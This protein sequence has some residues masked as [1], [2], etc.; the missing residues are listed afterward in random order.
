VI[1]SPDDTRQTARRGE[2]VSPLTHNKKP[3]RPAAVRTPDRQAA[4]LAAMLGDIENGVGTCRFERLTWPRC[5]GS[6]G[7]MRSYCSW[8]SSTCLFLRI[9]RTEKHGQQVHH[10]LGELC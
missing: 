3:P 9:V 7:A 5:L 10:I 8:V 1:R 2:T 6:S 4:P